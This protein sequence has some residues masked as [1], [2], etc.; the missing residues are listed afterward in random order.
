MIQA[1]QLW[2]I[3]CRYRQSRPTDAHLYS[4]TIITT[5]ERKASEQRAGGVVYKQ[6]YSKP[7]EPNMELL[8]IKHNKYK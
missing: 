3:A 6:A 5:H 1:A 2:Y 8:G 4:S 7:I